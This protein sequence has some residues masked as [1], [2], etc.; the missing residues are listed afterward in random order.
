MSKI[1]TVP[2]TENFLPHVVDYICSHYG[3]RE[4]DLS[5]LCLVFGGRR[6]ALFIKRDLARRMGK[7]FIPPRFFTIDEWMAY[8]A[9]G[10]QTPAQG[11]DL[12]HAY[13]IY[14]LAMSLCP[15]VCAGR[16]SFAQFLQ[17]A[18]E[19]LHFIEQLDLED[20]PLGSLE[21]LRE[22]AK[23]GF[24]V[25][26][27]INK[28]LMH[29]GV[30]RQAYHQE[31]DRR[32]LAP[33]GVQYRQAAQR[34]G[35]CDLSAFDEILF[36]NFFYLHRTENIVIKNIYDRVQATLLMQGD[37][38]RWPALLRSLHLVSRTARQSAVLWMAA[39]QG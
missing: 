33:R 25:P 26:E 32:Q 15:W 35:A 1:I 8:V 37:Q 39:H 23:I 13:T 16:E 9:Y 24:S 2:F 21:L 31:L 34:V 11:S 10:A 17:W 30:L 28:L 4:G 27:D 14:R 18:R 7:A 38:R 36:C 29:L 20:V 5:R 22:A 19:I 6:P 3:E 12:D